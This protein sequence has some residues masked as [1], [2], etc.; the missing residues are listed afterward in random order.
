MQNV[1]TEPHGQ[2]V[3]IRSQDILRHICRHLYPWEVETF[4]ISCFCIFEPIQERI[5]EQWYREN[6]PKPILG[7]LTRATTVI[8]NYLDHRS[9]AHLTKASKRIH[10]W[11]S[12]RDTPPPK[13]WVVEFEEADYF[14]GSYGPED[15]ETGQLVY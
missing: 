7:E 13:D 6:Y 8:A 5:D 12:T 11:A 9:R 10:Y 2:L 4:K 15:R 3:T 1:E 14:I